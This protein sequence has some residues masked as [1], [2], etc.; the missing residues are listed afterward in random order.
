MKWS[1]IPFRCPRCRLNGRANVIVRGWVT[2]YQCTA[3]SSHFKLGNPVAV[4]LTIAAPMCALGVALGYYLGETQLNDEQLDVV[5]V[6]FI[7]MF[8]VFMWWGYP[9]C[10]VALGR[11]EYVPGN[12]GD[13]SAK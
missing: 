10:L 2:T 1:T 9:K 13:R 7:V 12:N 4:S 11:F 3:C 8:S 5:L 6:G